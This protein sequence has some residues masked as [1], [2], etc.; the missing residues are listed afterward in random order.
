MQTILVPFLFQ[1]S[2]I[3]PGSNGLKMNLF[4]CR[5]DVDADD[6]VS[7]GEVQQVQQLAEMLHAH[8]HSSDLPVSYVVNGR[9]TFD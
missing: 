8:V 1:S 5:C 9:K 2:F 6:E 4:G 3:L 7:D